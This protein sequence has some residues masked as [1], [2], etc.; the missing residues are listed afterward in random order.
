MTMQ[1]LEALA[2]QFAMIATSTTLRQPNL[3]DSKQLLCIEFVP[4]FLK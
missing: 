4:C 2:F 3:Q 1:Q